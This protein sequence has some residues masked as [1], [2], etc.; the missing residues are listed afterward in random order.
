M[1]EPSV[2]NIPGMTV[3]SD[4]LHFTHEG[5]AVLHRDVHNLYGALQHKAAFEGMLERDGG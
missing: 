1:N 2:F 3:P 5:V 4:A